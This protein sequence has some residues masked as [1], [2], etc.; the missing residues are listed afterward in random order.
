MCLGLPIALCLSPAEKV[1]RKDKSLVLVH[2]QETWAKEFKAAFKLIATRR[3]L[4]LLPSFFISYFYNGFLSTWLTDYF[5]VRSRAFSSF[6]TNFAG[7]ASSFI[8]AGLLDRQSIFIKTRAKIAFTSIVVILTGTWIW[9]TILQKQFYDAPEPPSST[10]SRAVSTNLTP[11]SS[12]GPLVVRLS[13]NSST[14][15]S[16]STA[17]IYPRF[18]TTVVSFV[19]SRRWV[20][21]LHGLCSPR[22]TRTILSV[23]DSTSVLLCLR[24]FLRG[25][26]LMSWSIVMRCRLLPRSSTKQPRRLMVLL[27]E[28]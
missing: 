4:L 28:L 14:G 21:L 8:L 2:K 16:V 15:S 6:F 12:S 13:S 22:V 1:Q 9:A 11:W 24:L 10:G 17:Q 7:I 27:L 18:P 19:D 23:S 26:F 25:L 5:T 3:V 20:R